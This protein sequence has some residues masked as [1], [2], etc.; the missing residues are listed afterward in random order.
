VFASGVNE[1]G[2]L[3]TP[4]PFHHF[5]ALGI[6]LRSTLCFTVLLVKLFFK[7]LVIVGFE[8]SVQVF[9]GVHRIFKDLL[10]IS[11][12]AS[13]ILSALKIVLR[14]LHLDTLSL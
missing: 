5:L 11:R 4:H 9:A 1:V 13:Q 3:V 6:L 12:Y 14:M 7:E 10:L 2:N 8:E